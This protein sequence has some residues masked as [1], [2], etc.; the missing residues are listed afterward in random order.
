MLLLFFQLTFLFL[1]LWFWTW[2]E[3]KVV[4]DWR[5]AF[6]PTP[7]TTYLHHPNAMVACPKLQ[8]PTL[9]R[10]VKRQNAVHLGKTPSGLMSDGRSWIHSGLNLAEKSKLTRQLGNQLAGGI[11]YF[12]KFQYLYLL[13]KSLKSESW[14]ENSK[15]Q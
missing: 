10:R 6:T 12:K 13:I 9:N 15:S 8:L 1:V 14:N 5:C 3:A 7:L 4:L 2:R 11:N